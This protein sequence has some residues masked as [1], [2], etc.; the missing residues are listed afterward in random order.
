LDVDIDFGDRDVVLSKIMHH[1]AKLETGKKHNTGIYVTPIPHNPITN[2]STIDY[3]DAE[4]RG[5]FKLDF[6]NVSLYKNVKDESHLIHLSKKEPMWELLEHSEVVDQL[7]HIS[8]HSDILKKLKPKSVLELACVLAIIRP[9]KRHLLNESWETI[10][11]E[12][13]TKPSNEQYYFK[14]SHAVSYAL[15]VVVHLNLL[16]ESFT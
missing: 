15:A 12:V 3:K 6:L 4:S 2:I 10:H 11:R 8:G 9:A 13:W 16:C 7:F 14:K 5:Y 1:V